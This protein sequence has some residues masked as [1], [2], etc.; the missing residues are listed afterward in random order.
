MAG[1]CAAFGEGRQLMQ[2]MAGTMWALG[3]ANKAPAALW[4]QPTGIALANVIGAYAPKGAAS[5]AASY[6]NL[7]NPGTNNAA[8]GVAPT[9][10]AAT[11]W[12][13][14]GSQWLTTGIV[15]SAGWTI[16]V[17]FSDVPADNNGCAIGG[18]KDANTYFWAYPST[19]VGN[20][21]YMAYGNSPVQGGA[22][23]GIAQ[24][25]LIISAG[26]RY[27]N[28]ILKSTSGVWTGTGAAIYIMARNNNGTTDRIMTGNV[29]AAIVLN[30]QLTDAQALELSNNMAA[31]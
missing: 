2:S 9:F 18:F 19:P 29:Q 28:G 30:T 3:A 7:A 25:V 24:G 10:N 31:L 21:Y 11:G 12:G 13:G 14:T 4:Y 5:L 16:G 1:L 17:R 6:V 15:P 27:V 20:Q 26:K 23:T 8:P 22:G